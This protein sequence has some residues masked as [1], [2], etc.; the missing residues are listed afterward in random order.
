MGFFMSLRDEKPCK[1]IDV[2][3]QACPYPVLEAKIALKEL[4]SGNILEL[5]SDWEA[6]VKESLPRFC[7]KGNY[8]YETVEIEPDKIWKVLIK[9]A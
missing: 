3:G 8:E 9:K 6:S 7:K 1:T 5:I 2:R 4:E